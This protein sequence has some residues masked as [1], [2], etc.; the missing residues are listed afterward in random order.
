MDKQRTYTV[1]GA[2]GHI[3]NKV[4]RDLIR[5]G[6]TVRA[7]GRD[8]ERLKP[9]A[10]LGAIP[11]VGDWQDADFIEEAF[12]GAD[13]ALLMAQ[14]H[15]TARDY[16]GAFARVGANYAN[17]A[18]KTRLPSAV[19]I[20]SLGVQD[21]RNRGLI[22][23]HA[24]VEHSLNAVDGLN[25][26]HLRAPFFFEN[27]FYFLQ[28]MRERGV[29]RSPISPQAEFDSVWTR[30][31]ADV[32]LRLLMR[33]DFQGKSEIEVLGQSRLSLDKIAGLI[34]EQ[35]GRPFPAEKADRDA[36][37]EGMVAAGF[38]RD[39]A[40][41]MND[42]WDAFNRGLYRAAEPSTASRMPSRIEGFLREELAP[43]ILPPATTAN[44]P[45]SEAA[46][47]PVLSR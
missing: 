19:F 15:R 27:L 10:D 29:L 16:R 14:A 38:G 26:V 17:A 21:E 36:D 39:F 47:E 22:L 37:I 3:G 12:R 33:L 24:D 41:L 46:M 35:V 4:A 7:M 30:D 28:P 32:A 43:A 5:V 6:H 40:T 42:T 1:T 9:L 34:G 31:V 2:T 13:A 11:F 44:V 18:Q 45:T 8:K 25:V 20:S 23:I